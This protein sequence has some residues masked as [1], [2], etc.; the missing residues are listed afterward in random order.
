MCLAIPAKIVNIKRFIAEVD[1]G[2]G[3]VRE[4]NVYLVD[5]KIGDYVLV[6]AGYAI[7]VID[8]KTV[9]ETLALWKSMLNE[10]TLK[11]E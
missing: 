2:G 8:E 1:F 7:E 9:E 5:A 3:I 10:T 4:V 11:D 6:H